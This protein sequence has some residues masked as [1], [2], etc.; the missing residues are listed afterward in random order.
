[1]I[2]Y[3]AVP[4]IALLEGG[5]LCFNKGGINRKNINTKLFLAVVFILPIV[6]FAFRDN[7]IG[8]D[9]N[10]YVKEFEQIGQ[11]PFWD[12]ISK[13]YNGN[14]IN[15]VEVGFSIMNW[16]IAKI[17]ISPKFFLLVTALIMNL[18]YARAIYFLSPMPLTS[19]LAYFFLSN[20][21]YNL[22]VMRQGIAAGIILNA[23]IFLAEKRFIKYSILVFI[24]SLFHS[25]SVAFF[26]MIIPII[27]VKSKKTLITVVISVFFAILYSLDI[28]HI[29]VSKYFPHFEY[30]F[31]NNYHSNQ[32]FGI[33][34]TAYVFLDIIIILMLISKFKK[35]KEESNLI[36]VCTVALAMGAAS[37]IMMPVFGI[38][39]R[40]SKFFHSFIMIAMAYALNGIQNRRDKYVLNCI[41]IGCSFVYYAYIILIDAYQIVPFLFYE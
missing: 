28:V 32:R 23:V 4:F 27:L 11:I 30:Y 26:F 6:I 35:E 10:V 19:T 7:S 31:R 18:L 34:S 21:L 15:D 40:V 14:I 36:I 29:I 17:S 25:F 16:S 2:I 20:F 3:F 22:N 9:T 37:L 12:I 1:M 8:I 38:Y 39:E 41:G 5:A 24:A 13:K 33:T